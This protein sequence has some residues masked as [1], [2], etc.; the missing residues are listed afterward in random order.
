MSLAVPLPEGPFLEGLS[1]A[2]DSDRVAG[3]VSEH[4]CAGKTIEALRATYIRHKGR[5]GSLVGWRVRLEGESLEIP[6]CVRVAPLAR[7]R[8]EAERFEGLSCNH[9]FWKKP[10][11]LDEGAG[12]LLIGFPFDRSLR[13]LR[14][15]V[16]VTR[17]RDF[18][19]EHLP[20]A[21]APGWRVSKESTFSLVRYKPERRAVLRWELVLRHREKKGR[22]HFGCYLRLHADRTALR[23]RRMK[24]AARRTGVVCPETLALVSD[25][26]EVESALRGDPLDVDGPDAIAQV[27]AAGELLAKL[28]A[29]IPAAD[30]ECGRSPED[31]LDRCRQA[32]VDLGQLDPE[33]SARADAIVERLMAGQPGTEKNLFLHGD[34]HPGQVLFDR[35]VPAFVDFDRSLMGSAAFDLASF[36]AHLLVNGHPDA[37]TLADVLKE[38]YARSGQLPANDSR[39]WYLGSALLCMASTAFRELAPDWPDRTG[40]ML[41][42]AAG[43]VEGRQ[44]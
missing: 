7:L 12:I 18:L 2:L 10:A 32:A 41:S 15:L 26:F 20:E 6:V 28:H 42:M 35:T 21:V 25:G 3:L 30:D 19:P 33:W 24:Q 31:E 5:D 43:V 22:E 1:T 17:I 11:A 27:A 34:F 36:E 8:S 9:L 4:L 29:T 39:S 44:A 37:R 38:G 16:R 14:K 23:A 13:W 40:K